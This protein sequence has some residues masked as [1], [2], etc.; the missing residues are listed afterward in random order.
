MAKSA[1]E[2]IKAT[3]GAKNASPTSAAQF[4]VIVNLSYPAFTPQYVEDCAREVIDGKYDS[5][6]PSAGTDVFF[7]TKFGGEVIATTRPMGD[8]NLKKYKLVT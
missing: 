8:N 4:G 2:C 3:G 5:I 7:V 6:A 1:I